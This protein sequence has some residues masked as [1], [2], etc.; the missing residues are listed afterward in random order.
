MT[1]E[2]VEKTAS[3]FDTYGAVAWWERPIEEFLPGG[4]HVRRVRRHGVRAREEHP[5]RVVRLGFEPRGGAA[6]PAGAHVAG[7]HVSRRQR[8]ASRLVSELAARRSR[9]ARTSAV[10]AGAD[11]RL[12]H[13]P[14]RPED[15]EVGR[16]RRSCRR[17]SSRRAA[18]KCCVS[19]WRAATTAK[20]C[21]SA[22]KSSRGSSRRT[23]SSATR[24]GTSSRTCTT[25]IPPSMR[26]RRDSSRKSIASSSRDTA[27]LA[28]KVLAA[29]D[30][31]D[32]PTI[33]QAVNAFATVDLSALYNDISKDRLYTFAA[34]SRER[35]SAQ[36]AM[37]VMADGLARLIAPIL[38]VSAEQLWQHLPGHARRVGPPVAVPV[39]R[40]ARRRSSIADLL[41]RWDRLSELARTGARRNRAAAQRQAHRQLAAGPRRPLG[42]KGRRRVSREVQARDL[43]MLFI[44]SD[45]ELRPAPRAARRASRHRARGRREVR[46]VLA[47]REVGVDAIPSWAGICDRC[48]DALA[49]T[50]NA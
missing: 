8:P 40:R 27:S 7:G 46:T 21:A 33:F 44:V 17:T 13:R 20:S 31:Y 12:P 36:T 50:T 2:M 42:V 37:Y 39:S 25:S 43:P 15:V 11:A 30:A 1:A 16:Q 14:R 41:A 45:V 35:R 38:S 26:C 23:G 32:Y 9:H 3:V 49:Q 28:L 4:S 18:P 10:Q 24:R 5:R 48:Q 19:G 34:R 6:L 47:R 22:R 29:Y